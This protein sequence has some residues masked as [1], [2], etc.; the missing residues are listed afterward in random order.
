MPVLLQNLN[1][2]IIIAETENHRLFLFGKPSKF[3]WINDVNFY[4]CNRFQ[5]VCKTAGLVLN[6]SSH[7]FIHTGRTVFF[8]S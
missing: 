3:L 2:L 1:C 6:F 7:H 8:L 5:H 4:V